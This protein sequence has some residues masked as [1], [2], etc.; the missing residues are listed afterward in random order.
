MFCFLD[1][2]QS[3]AVHFFIE[4]FALPITAYCQ[5]QYSIYNPDMCH[6]SSRLLHD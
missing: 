5:D 1:F 3:D 4:I 2:E 6:A